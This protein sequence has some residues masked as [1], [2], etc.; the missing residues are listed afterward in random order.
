MTDEQTFQQ[1]ADHFRET[2]LLEATSAMLE[3]DERTGLPTRAGA[4]R[5]E[6]ITL[7]SGMIHR[8]KTDP[9]IGELL[10][11]LAASPLATEGQL[12]ITASIARLL[13][14]FRRNSR[15]PIDLVEATSKATVLGQQA[16]EKARA[17]DSW[18]LFRPHLK[19][20]FGLR[21]RE[22][23]LLCDGGSLYDALLDQ[24]EEG[25]RSEELTK[26]FASLRDELVQLVQDL[27]A[28]RHPPSGESW[29]RSVPVDRQRKISHW[30]AEQFGYQFERGRLDETSHPFCTTLGP[31]D[32]RILTRYQADYFP[33][34][35]YSTLHETG[36]GLY[37]Q[38]LPTDWYGLPP[39]TYASLGVHE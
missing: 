30:I 6:Q 17:S 14:N 38:G 31:D 3:W 15:L 34:A 21:R 13:K 9:H 10:E 28:S 19:E 12:P 32:C 18:E 1:V 24:Y 23:E 5:A 2:A 25:A 7:L 11:R 8:R 26:V 39:G 35:F 29:Q 36:H 22:A 27:Q 4:Y 37:E 16:W 20:I 33:S